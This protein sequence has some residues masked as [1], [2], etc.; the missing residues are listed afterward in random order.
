MKLRRVLKLSPK[1]SILVLLASV[2][3]WNEY[4]ALKLKSL[5]WVTPSKNDKNFPILIVAD[6]QFIGY[7]N[8]PFFIGWLSRWDSDRYLSRGFSAAFEAVQPK[9]IV[10]LGDLFDE[11]VQMS[12][13]EFEWTMERFKA[14]FPETM[15][16]PTVYLPGDNDIGGEM[17]PV[18]DRLVNKFQRY[19]PHSFN[20]ENVEGHFFDLA[21]VYPML[22]NKIE[23]I[24]RAEDS[25]AKIL[26]SHVPLAR[27]LDKGTN[28]ALAEYDPDLILSAH[29]HTAEVYVR[30]RNSF[31]F[32]RFDLRD[33]INF[34]ISSKQPIV[35]IQS[36]TVS[37]RM[38]VPNMGYGVLTLVNESPAT[39]EYT[40]LWLPGRYPQV[41]A[42][43]ICL[44]VVFYYL[45]RSYPPSSEM[46]SSVEM[47]TVRMSRGEMSTPW[48]FDIV[49]P[50]IIIRVVGSSLADRAGLQN[51][52]QI[53]EIQG[54][55]GC[56]FEDIQ[57]LF[58]SALHEIDLVVL[59]GVMCRVNEAVVHPEC[60]QCSTC[61]TSLKNVG[62]H[63]IDEKFYCDIH[64]TQRLQQTKIPAQKSNGRP[65][66]P[67]LNTMNRSPLNPDLVVRTPL[68]GLQPTR[69]PEPPKGFYQPEILAPGP[70]SPPQPPRKPPLDSFAKSSVYT[71]KTY[72]PEAATN[73]EIITIGKLSQQSTSATLEARR[74][75]RT[76]APFVRSRSVR[77]IQWPPEPETE[78]EQ[79][80]LEAI[81]YW[82]L[83]LEP[84]DRQRKSIQDLIN[85]DKESSKK[86][87]RN[88][89]P[90]KPKLNAKRVI[91]TPHRLNTPMRNPLDAYVEKLRSQGI[92][93]P[94]DLSRTKS[95]SNLTLIGP[96][97][98]VNISWSD[99]VKPIPLKP[100]TQSLK[101]ENFDVDSPPNGYLKVDPQ[102]SQNISPS[103]EPDSVNISDNCDNN[104][105][106]EWQA[107]SEILEE[108]DILT[109]VSSLRQSDAEEDAFELPKFDERTSQFLK[110][111][112]SMNY[113][114]SV[115]P[116][117]DDMDRKSAASTIKEGDD[118]YGIGQVERKKWSREE[119]ERNFVELEFE[120]DEH[121][122]KLC[123]DQ[124]ARTPLPGDELEEEIED[125]VDK[126]VQE[127]ENER[128]NAIQ[129]IEQHQQSLQSQQEQLSQL[130]DNAIK[131]LKETDS[132]KL[133]DET[134]H[135]MS[136]GTKSQLS[137]NV[138]PYSPSG[139]ILQ[140]MLSQDDNGYKKTTIY[141]QQRVP[142]NPPDDGYSSNNIFT[143]GIRQHGTLMS[144]NTMIPF[145]EH[146]K[147]QIRGAYVLATGL[148]WCPEHFT[149]A[150]PACNRRL[151]DTGFVEEKGKKYCEKCFETLIAP[152]CSKCAMPITADCLTALQKQW[153][154][155]CFVCHHCSHP[156]GNS[157][158]YLENGKPYCEQDW[159]MLFTTKC[160]SCKYPIE[161]GDRW[162]EAIGS[163]FHSNCFSCTVCQTN[164][165]GQSFYAKNGLPFCRIHA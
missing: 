65:A 11:G 133:A 84:G 96:P 43:V 21:S 15:S 102:F 71:S 127:L 148:T 17:E 104:E 160:V 139:K 19:F 81:R 42:Y 24:N 99:L 2:L 146:C 58:Y 119:D 149:C 132:R 92:P 77:G 7:R 32:N 38:G 158:F 116:S 140:Y 126:E 162:V 69:V 30:D 33:R 106:D 74:M 41:Y 44:I 114:D 136:N 31:Q 145:C 14:V 120:V 157:A 152:I 25:K 22:S 110:E 150:N 40:V 56:T 94:N 78:R 89:S 68:T 118:E 59:R 111:Q 9:M 48:G 129:V 85:E 117:V 60:F 93:T 53:D 64:G 54:V 95:A 161:A 70:L 141:E 159:N 163:A 47:V 52:D 67:I 80:S 29:D 73:E 50:G 46:D 75:S 55:Q 101:N 13:N 51:G 45:L 36:P 151:L 143:D 91:Q 18:Y 79:K 138:D 8:E 82:K 35:E 37:Y 76:F 154:P 72:N 57:E 6:P 124:L 4:L 115:S 34:V 100:Q 66:P 121:V 63:Y 83:T 49:P 156:F 109:D 28:E 5:S 144:S 97:P 26:M 62:H 142:S 16:V 1:N 23:I 86:Y 87:V 107:K 130:L 131:Y 3:F 137:P 134:N 39:A 88:V 10:F 113:D 128:E 27:S 20:S 147:R 108:K 12:S 153:H 164:L 122:E 125:G 135:S 98:A 61:G 105:N 103:P 112:L 165:E 123:L 90:E 155:E